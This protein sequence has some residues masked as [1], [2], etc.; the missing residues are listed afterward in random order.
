YTLNFISKLYTSLSVIIIT[1][2]YQFITDF[3]ENTNDL[4]IKN[5]NGDIDAK[6]PEYITIVASIKNVGPGGVVKNIA[7]V[8]GNPT[9]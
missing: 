2:T 5:S 3:N 7:Y 6:K 8:N 4:V 9:N 1:S